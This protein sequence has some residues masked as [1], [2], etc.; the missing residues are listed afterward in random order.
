MFENVYGPTDG[1]TPARLTSYKLTLLAF[2]SGE[3]KVRRH[4]AETEPKI[5]EHTDELVFIENVRFCTHYAGLR[6]PF[7]LTSYSRY[8]SFRT[9][10]NSY[11]YHWYCIAYHWN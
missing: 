5:L 6:S 1:R 3:L 9:I 11:H 4:N 7:T 8:L 10:K 2:G